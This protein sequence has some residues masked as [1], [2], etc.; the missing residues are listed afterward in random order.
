[1]LLKLLS[2]AD[3][4]R[5]QM[6]VVGM[7]HAGVVAGRIEALGIPVQDLGMDYGIPSPLGLLRLIGIIR[8]WRPH[9]VQ[10]WM[11]HADL[12]GGLAAAVA[13]SVPTL[14]GIRHSN[15]DPAVNKRMTLATARLC[16]RMSRRLPE[17]IICCGEAARRAH[18]EFGYAEEKMEVIPNGF[19]VGA[20][21]P[22]PGARES[23]L[24]E[25]QLPPDAVL[26]GQIG[27]CDAQKDYET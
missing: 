21:R 15:L 13:G 8:D 18:I 1:M 26:V 3:R 17:K 25:L 11:Y 20:F 12:L 10:T 16:A 4:S 14:W 2:M 23:L 24:S 7:V 6:R 19:D 5:F 9:L 27:R 22:I